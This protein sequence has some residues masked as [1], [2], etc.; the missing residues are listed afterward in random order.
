MAISQVN[1]VGDFETTVDPNDVRVWASCLVDIETSE[2]VF[3]GNDLDSF[4]E[5]LKPRNSIVYFHNL[6]FDGEFILWWLL[7]N[8][9]KYSNS[10][11]GGTFETL[12]TDDGQFYYITVYF[13]KKNKKYKKVTFY[14]SL[15]KL[16]FKVST[17]S[18]AFELKDEKLVIDYKAK[19]EIGHVLTEQEKQYIINDCRIVAQALKIQMDKG[20]KKMTNASDAMNG[21]KNIISKE[22]FE[23]W[24]PVLPV[25]LD[26]DIRRAYKGG[27][28]YLMERF[29]NKQVPLGITLDVNSL[30][31]WV[32]RTKLLP[33]GYPMYYEGK[34]EHDPNYPLYI[35]H[36]KCRFNLKEDHIPCLQLK[37]NRRFV[38]TEYLTTSRV[39]DDDEPVELYLTS[40]DYQL[41]IDHYIIEDETYINGFKFR[42]AYGMF[43]DYI[44]YWM[45]IK[46]TTT[47]AVRQLAKLMLNSLYGRFALNPVSHQKVMY[48]DDDEIVRYKILDRD[49]AKEYGLPEP[50]NRDPVYTALGCF[51]TSYARE[52]TVRS[53]QSVYDRFIYADTDSLHLVGDEIPEGLE[54]HPTHLG[55]FKHEGTFCYSSYIRAKTYMETM[56]ETKKAELKN[57][58]RLMNKG[59]YIQ[60]NKKQITVP[61]TVRNYCLLLNQKEEIV[62]HKGFIYYQETKV[63]CAGMPD[64]VKESVTYDN[65][66]SGSTFDGKLMPRRFRGGVV[67]METT[68]TIK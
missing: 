10:H 55:A 38:E 24:F 5:F 22:R 56:M 32:M 58:C 36:M 52:K 45:H 60:R 59:L 63:T 53:A 41:L 37:N 43:N 42:A 29:R 34:Y 4:M 51:V 12:I 25:A 31:P 30:Y 17:I 26:A 21:Y 28:T 6:K 39:G 49:V 1:F 40:V 61:D 57:Y 8:G 50:E 66:K 64:N 16:P 19:R 2:T 3:I 11:E 7:K 62:R 20:L 18:K 47:G 67:L 35:V 44:D 23:K 15:K 48:L 13:E 14:D 54:I 27:F 68:F 33:Y 46:E 65:F 9:F